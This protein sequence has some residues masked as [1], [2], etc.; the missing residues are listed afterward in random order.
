MSKYFVNFLFVYNFRGG[1]DNINLNEIIP[2]ILGGEILLTI[3]ILH[4]YASIRCVKLAVITWRKLMSREVS[5][6]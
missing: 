2:L 1:E 3:K 6:T 4:K 5:C